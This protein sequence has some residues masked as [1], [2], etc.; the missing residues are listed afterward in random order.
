[1]KITINHTAEENR[2]YLDTFDNSELD[3]FDLNV[4]LS[5]DDDSTTTDIIRMAVKAMII[6]G[7]AL[8]SIVNSLIDVAYRL[9][10]DNG[11]DIEDYE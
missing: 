11:I 8:S 4:E 7:Y 6:E 1:M 5:T 2:E 9:A 3:I 10:Y